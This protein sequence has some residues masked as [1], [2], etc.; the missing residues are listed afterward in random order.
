ALRRARPPAARRR[1]HRVR[2]DARDALRRQ[3]GGAA[4]ERRPRDDGREPPAGHRAGAARR[5]GGEDEDRAARLRPAAH[6]AGA[7][8]GVRGLTRIRV[9]VAAA[10][11]VGPAG[12]SEDRPLR[13]SVNEQLLVLL[14]LEIV[15]EL[16]V[17]VGDLLDL[18]EALP[19]VVLRNLVVLE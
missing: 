17:L 12:R 15:D 13:R 14:L 7:R 10:L 1:T 16:H 19:L 18:L 4:P 11:Q 5:G 3:G 6:R 2:S 9:F 8:G